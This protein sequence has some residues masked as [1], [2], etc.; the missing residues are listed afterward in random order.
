MSRASTPTSCKQPERWPRTAHTPRIPHS[1]RT[2][3]FLIPVSAPNG[4]PCNLTPS[5]HWIGFPVGGSGA[6]IPIAA[7]PSRVGIIPS[8]AGHRPLAIPHRRCR[9]FVLTLRHEPGSQALRQE[10]KRLPCLVALHGHN[11]G[12][13]GWRSRRS[14]LRQVSECVR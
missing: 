10:S 14:Q 12:V 13:P 9:N 1:Q 3:R 2:G 8:D 5:L 11:H 7:Y 6:F 4:I